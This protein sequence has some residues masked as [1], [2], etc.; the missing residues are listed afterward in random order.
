MSE[1]DKAV[2]D[3]YCR[4]GMSLT[5]LIRSFPQFARND[6]EEVYNEYRR[7]KGYDEADLH[8]GVSCNCS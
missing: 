6:V 3:A 2:V 5:T 8:G 7:S 1:R 4:V